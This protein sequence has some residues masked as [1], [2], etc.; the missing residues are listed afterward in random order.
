ML[1]PPERKAGGGA[2]E[3][4]ELEE[5]HQLDPVMTDW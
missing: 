5:E 3:L 4:A 2:V 1:P